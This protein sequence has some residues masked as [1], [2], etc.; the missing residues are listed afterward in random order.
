MSNPEFCEGKVISKS[1]ENVK[2]AIEKDSNCKGCSS[3]SICKT[4]GPSTGN[5]EMYIDAQYKDE[6]EIGEIVKLKIETYGYNYYLAL[7][8]FVPSLF[9]ILGMVLG[10]FL[11]K[12]INN[13]DY[14]VL[15]QVGM[16][17]IFAF[18]GYFISRKFTKR[19][20]EKGNFYSV[21]DYFPIKKD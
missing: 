7:A 20:V 21:V 15:L 12:N 11:S 19:L 3:Y 1:T 5:N 16:G 13:F 18:L 6:V 8:F 9:F 10:D 4:I 17:T 14:Q 2:I